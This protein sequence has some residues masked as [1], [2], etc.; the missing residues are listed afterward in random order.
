[1]MFSLCVLSS[2]EHPDSSVDNYIVKV[3]A[4]DGVPLGAK[5]RAAP[6]FPVHSLGS[7]N[8]KRHDPSDDILFTLKTPTLSSAEMANINSTSFRQSGKRKKSPAM[9]RVEKS[10]DPA[11]VEF[12]YHQIF[13]QIDR[14]IMVLGELDRY[15]PLSGG[16][17]V[18]P[19]QVVGEKSFDVSVRLVTGEK[20]MVAW[21][22]EERSQAGRGLGPK[23]GGPV[24]GVWLTC[25]QCKPDTAEV[26]GVRVIHRKSLKASALH[27]ESFVDHD[28][29]EKVEMEIYE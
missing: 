16:R 2:A 5:K 29:T 3:V 12:E 15:V 21:Y 4:L 25:V 7:C 6:K 1:M 8:L 22:E 18:T 23:G 20:V 17:F 27:K 10:E 14:S 28:V 26:L 19:I 24:Y 11:L 13:T 9:D